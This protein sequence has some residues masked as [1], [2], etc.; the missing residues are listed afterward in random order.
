MCPNREHVKSIFTT[1]AKYL[2][3]VLFVSYYVGG[4]AF[5]HTHY[6]L[7]YSITH[8]QPF[9][10]G[11]DGLPHHTHSSSAFNTIGELDD[12]MM[13]A[14]ALCLTLVTAWVLLSVF[15]QQHKYITPVCSVRN[16]SLRAPPF[17]IK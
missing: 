4:T 1:I 3:I 12:I 10:P 13:E 9:L 6:F 11:A 7:T 15:I 17:R 2:L 8:T 5:T 16:V 14:A